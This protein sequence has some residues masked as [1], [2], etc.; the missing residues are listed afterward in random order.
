M[1][2]ALEK[3]LDYLFKEKGF[4]IVVAKFYDSNDEVTKI[5][6]KTLENVGMKKEAVLRNRKIN[7]KT[8]KPENKIIYS[9]LKEEFYKE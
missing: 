6:S 3:V 2:E 8:K 7:E 5:K 4:N 9:I 1:E